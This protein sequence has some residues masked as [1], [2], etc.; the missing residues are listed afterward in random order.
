MTT[1]WASVSGYVPGTAMSTPSETSVAWPPE[2]RTV[3]SMKFMA[4]LPMKP[5]TKRFA[6]MVVQ[7]L[8][9]CPPAGA[10]RRS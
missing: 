6:G 5:A 8:R 10:S 2:P 7:L 3:A 9:A 4:G 1:D